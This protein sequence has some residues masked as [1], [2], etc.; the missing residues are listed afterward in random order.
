M[1]K[2]DDQWIAA[3]LKRTHLGKVFVMEI[4]DTMTN[5][6][7]FHEVFERSEKGLLAALAE[8][9]EREHVHRVAYQRDDM[10]AVSLTVAIWSSGGYLLPLEK[11]RLLHG[12]TEWPGTYTRTIWT[13][14]PK[15]ITK[16][17]TF[18]GTYTEIKAIEE[19]WG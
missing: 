6:R 1:Q 8:Y 5:R 12:E 16:E 14:V 9:K 4:S 10:F 11:W 19:D 18:L 17:S 7:L 13:P 15:G 2:T 3:W